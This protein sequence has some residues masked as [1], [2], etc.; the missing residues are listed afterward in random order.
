[1]SRNLIIYKV[2]YVLKSDPW[3]W[4][5]ANNKFIKIKRIVMTPEEVDQTDGYWRNHRNVENKFFKQ[6]EGL[7]D[8]TYSGNKYRIKSV[9]KA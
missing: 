9:R 5:S 6:M 1:M 8:T 3:D 4:G 2:Q 7:D